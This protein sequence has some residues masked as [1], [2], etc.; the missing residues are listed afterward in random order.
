MKVD[1]DLEVDSRPPLRSC[2]LLHEVVFSTLQTT[3]EIPPPVDVDLESY[4]G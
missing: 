3:P 1:S 2:I 4:T